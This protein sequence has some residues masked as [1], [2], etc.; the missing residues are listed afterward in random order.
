MLPGMFIDYKSTMTACKIILI[1]GLSFTT[2]V[3]H[4][5]MAV[6]LSCHMFVMSET[7]ASVLFDGVY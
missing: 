2:H 4:S 6:G 1:V 7:G 5:T 3:I